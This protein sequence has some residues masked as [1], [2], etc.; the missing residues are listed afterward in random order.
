ME[1]NGFLFGLIM[2]VQNFQA[3]VR[4]AT[5]SFWVEQWGLVQLVPLPW[6]QPWPSREK[7]GK[8]SQISSPKHPKHPPEATR[9]KKLRY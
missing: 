5:M 9:N 3:N 6:R 2:D 7:M 4:V 1:W 8:L